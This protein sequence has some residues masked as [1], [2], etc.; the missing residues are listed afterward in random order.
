MVVHLVIFEPVTSVRKI[1]KFC[2]VSK[3]RQ[4]QKYMDT[5]LPKIAEKLKEFEFVEKKTWGDGIVI[6]GENPSEICEAALNMRDLFAETNWE[7]YDL[8]DLKIRISIHSG[9]YAHGMD[10]FSN[11]VGFC[12]RTIVGTARLEPVTAPGQIWITKRSAALLDE[13]MAGQGNDFFTMDPIGK[14]YLPKDHGSLDVWSL[15][16]SNEPA[17]EKTIIQSI[18]EE[19]NIH[20]L[21]LK[22]RKKT[23][24]IPK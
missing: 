24:R 1:G 8:P 5:M 3:D 23:L 7:K 22:K 17:L 13:Q 10:F 9:S 14:I 12:G 11:R 20:Y 16:Q 4:M 18:I 2:F 6:I 19:N 21:K 15:R